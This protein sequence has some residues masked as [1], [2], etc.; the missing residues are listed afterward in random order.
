VLWDG[1]FRLELNGA[2][3]ALLVRALGRAGTRALGQVKRT[4]P[5]P[6]RPSLP[7]LWH[8]EQLVAVPHLGIVLPSLARA[9]TVTVRFNPA[10]PLAG[11]PFL[12]DGDSQHETVCFGPP[13]AYVRGC[14]GSP[15]ERR[16]SAEFGG[17]DQVTRHRA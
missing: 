12:A 17:E 3:P 9:A 15:P 6:V 16:R 11:S 4:L 10:L 1:R 14:C 13:R 2:A 8:G 5:A 7:S